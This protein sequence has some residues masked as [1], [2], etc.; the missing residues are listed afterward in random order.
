MLLTISTS[1]KNATDI[2]FLL[3]KHPERYQQFSTSFGVVDIFYPVAENDKCTASLILDIDPVGMVRK[4]TITSTSAQ[5]DHYINDRAYVASSFLSV[6]IANVYGDALKGKCPERP[7]L[8]DVVMPLTATIAVMPSRGGE[9]LLYRLFEPLGYKVDATR[10]QLD[11]AFPQWGMSPYYT[12]ILEHKTTLKNL[13]SHIYVLMPVLDNQKHYYVD[14]EE[15]EKFLNHGKEWISTHPEKELITHRYFKYKKSLAKTALYR[16]PDDDH[17]KAKITEDK[18]PQPEEEFENSIHLNEQR[19][20]TVISV[21]KSQES[22]KVIDLGCGEGKL[23]QK[24]LKIKSVEKIAGLDISLRSLEIAAERLKLDRMPD[25]ERE[26]IDL[27]HGSLLYRDKRVDA[28]DTATVSEVIEHIAPSRLEIFECILF[29]AS[30]PQTIIITTPNSE[31]NRLYEDL[32]AGQFRHKDHYFEWTR[33]E[34]QEWGR[35]ISTRYNYRVRFLP[36]G[37]EMETVGAPTQMAV[38]E[39]NK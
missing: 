1:G 12:V 18:N 23:L 22:K 36:I 21:I 17:T 34:F 39:K 11:T 9:K 26:R 24:L 33:K 7:E 28:Y 32:A 37:Q 19:L 3:H 10:H 5:F 14:S 2:G 4:T 30:C 15:V 25:K 8:T 29:K 38:F 31:Y 35:K 16:L 20:G 27:M 13:L 6:A